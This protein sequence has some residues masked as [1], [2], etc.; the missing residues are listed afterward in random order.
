MRCGQTAD[1]GQSKNN[2]QAYFNMYQIH[3]CGGFLL[4]KWYFI[5]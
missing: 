2:R 4:S 5:P 1:K 3:E